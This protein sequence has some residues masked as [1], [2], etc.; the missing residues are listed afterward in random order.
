[1]KILIVKCSVSVSYYR[2]IAPPLGALYLSAFLKQAGYPSVR[3]LHL[4][5]LGMDAAGL[6][7]ELL[8]FRPDIVGLSAITAEG[9]S[10]HELARC[11]K[12]E[13]PGALVVA[14]G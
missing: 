3:V 14:G 11:V 10:M 2:V 7:A 6:R 8:S 4:D 1:M 13:L 9:K 12:E 5:A